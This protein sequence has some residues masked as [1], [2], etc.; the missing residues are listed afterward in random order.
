[1]NFLEAVQG[2]RDVVLLEGRC[3][4][5]WLTGEN[6]VVEIPTLVKCDPVWVLV[7]IVSSFCYQKH[8]YRTMTFSI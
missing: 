7:L 2:T 3:G 6:Q 5:G 8:L 1:M 4:Q